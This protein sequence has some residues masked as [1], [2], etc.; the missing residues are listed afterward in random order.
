MAQIDRKVYVK[1]VSMSDEMQ[2][3]AIKCA[4]QAL[5]KFQINK[6][7][8]AFIKMEFDQKY[9]PTWYCIVGRN[10]NQYVT[11]EIEHFIVFYLGQVSIIL[12][13]SG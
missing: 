5:E 4:N 11:N 7:I 3:D 9:N 12:Y 6:E 8:A 2:Q 13:K 10:F 1:N